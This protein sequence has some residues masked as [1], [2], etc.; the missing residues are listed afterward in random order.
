VFHFTVFMYILSGI[1]MIVA[2]GLIFKDEEKKGGP[3]LS[4][5]FGLASLGYGLYLA[6]FFT[7]GTYFISYRIFLVPPIVIAY[8]IVKLV[9]KRKAKKTKQAQ[10]QA[11][12]QAPPP[13]QAWPAQ[14]QA[15]WPAPQPG[16]PQPGQWPAQPQAQ[17]PAQPPAGQ[18]PPAPT[19]NGQFPQAPP[20]APYAPPTQPTLTSDD[21]LGR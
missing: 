3:V 1:A 2:G 5:L 14:Q 18:Y 12:W 13:P 19:W 11:G 15:Q 8:A 17:W 20:P 4:A 16:Q 10:V 9:E 6:L 7:G 21:I